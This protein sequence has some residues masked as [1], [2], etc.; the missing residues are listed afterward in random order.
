MNFETKESV[1]HIIITYILTSK[2]NSSKQIVY[3]FLPPRLRRLRLRLVGLG[4]EERNGN[5]DEA[6][7]E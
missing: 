6:D 3:F 5:G 7:K 2:T 4:L 1:L